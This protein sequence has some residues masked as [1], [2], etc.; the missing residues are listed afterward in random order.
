MTNLTAQEVRNRKPE[1]FMVHAAAIVD[2]AP[3]IRTFAASEWDELHDDG[4][5]WIAAIVQEAVARE[6]QAIADAVA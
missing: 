6:R 1:S 5:L 4:K 3:V 2:S